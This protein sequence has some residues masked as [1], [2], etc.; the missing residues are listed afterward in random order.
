MLQEFQTPSPPRTEPS[1]LEDATPVGRL[2]FFFSDRVSRIFFGW[3]FFWTLPQ[4]PPPR[5]FVGQMGIFGVNRVFLLIEDVILTLCLNIQLKIRE[6][7]LRFFGGNLSTKVRESENV[8]QQVRH[9]LTF[10][11]KNWT[12]TCLVLT[13]MVQEGCV[14]YVEVLLEDEGSE[15]NASNNLTTSGRS[16]GQESE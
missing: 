5:F 8:K 9:S 4:R 7:G 14:S 2:S 15:K 11:T 10:N 12:M 16:V 3:A 1:S 13:P 6:N